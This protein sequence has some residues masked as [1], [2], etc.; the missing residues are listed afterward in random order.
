MLFYVTEFEGAKIFRNLSSIKA[1]LQA[2]ARP[3]CVCWC[4]GDSN[5]LAPGRRHPNFPFFVK[6]KVLQMGS[7]DSVRE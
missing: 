4:K 5:A 2:D 3:F 7:K 6:K 1:F